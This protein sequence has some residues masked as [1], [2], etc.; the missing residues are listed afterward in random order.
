MSFPFPSLLIRMAS[1]SE[2]AAIL[3]GQLAPVQQNISGLVGQVSTLQQSMTSME[4]QQAQQ[5][6]AI[7]DIAKAQAE[8]A[9]RHQE[10]EKKILEMEAALQDM[11]TTITNITTQQ[12]QQTTQ[13][14]DIMEVDG[15]SQQGRKRLATMPRPSGPWR[16]LAVPI[17]SAPHASAS[18]PEP[19]P[20]S[21]SGKGVL[22]SN[23][24]KLWIKGFQRGVLK[25]IQEKV[26]D[27][28]K[29][30][31]GDPDLFEGAKPLF[32]NQKAQF[33]VIMGS[34]AQAKA[35][36]DKHRAIE[37]KFLWHDPKVAGDQ[38]DK[39]LKVQSD[40]PRLDK[41]IRLVVGALWK[42]VEDQTKDSL[43]AGSHLNCSGGGGDLWLE[44]AGDSDTL[45][46]VKYVASKHDLI[47]T[48]HKDNLERLG[49]KE[50]THQTIITA[51]RAVVGQQM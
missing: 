39:E 13:I 11:R 30:R 2:F 37:Q 40:K 36:L 21:E 15:G 9:L 27:S 4:A 51:A 35:V 34:P 46:S 14:A 1:A 8:Q 26:F 38:G 23:K 3:A 43:P 41:L 24:S 22:D 31:I 25:S 18:T 5:A 33:A 49:I 48:A 10:H 16:P 20:T 32:S 29:A 44:E 45:F 6:A 19:A 50:D 7:G 28:L 47:I 42:S 17:G 12:Q